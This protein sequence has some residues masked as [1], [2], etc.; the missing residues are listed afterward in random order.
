[1]KLLVS[2]GTVFAS[3]F[4]AEYFVKRGHEVYVL[5][6]NSRQQ[7]PG[8]NL[9]NCDRH[10][11]GNVLK[12]YSFDAVLDITAYTGDDVR[13]L[14]EALGEFGVYIMVSSSAVYPQTLPQPFKEFQPCGENIYWGDYGLNKI[15][16]EKYLLEKVPNS[17]IIRPP[18]LYG[19]MNNLYREAFVFECAEQN[20]PFYIPKDGKMPLQF[21]DIE[22]MCRFME[23]LIQ[24]RP[25]ERIYNVGNPQSVDICEWVELCYSVLHKK[26]EFIYVNGEIPQRSYFPFLDYAYTLD[27]SRQS[28]LMDNTKPLVSGLQESYEWYKDNKDQVR[29]KPLIAYIDENLKNLS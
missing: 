15:A 18:Y 25:D 20:R 19:K 16:A 2:G 17:Y 11:L 1:M 22:D 13:D 27:V 4:T 3:R 29:T 7:S 6:R 14:T 5:N 24:N 26:P 28:R 8:V 23:I 10:A 12:T 9:I 21:F